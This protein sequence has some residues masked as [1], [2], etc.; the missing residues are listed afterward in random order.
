MALMNGTT[1]V[2]SQN[3]KDG[4]RVYVAGFL[5]LGDGVLLVRKNRPEWQ[6]KYLNGIGGEV[7]P[8]EEPDVAMVRE[9][10]EEVGIE[11]TDW[12]LFANEEG[13]GYEVYFYRCRLPRNYLG[14][15]NKVNDVGE[16][17]EW[18]PHRYVR[19]P[20]IGNL[21]WLLPLASDPR[22]IIVMAKT[23]SDIRRI[24]TW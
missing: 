13:P 14:S 9:F 23:T 18:H 12:N 21:N 5:L 19:D 4:K 2:V 22:E 24:G 3:M 1:G 8:N 17:L 15:F 10:K 7:L 20:M 16:E 6:A 11:I